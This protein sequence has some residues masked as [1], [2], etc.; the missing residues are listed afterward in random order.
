MKFSRKA[1]IIVPLLNLAQNCTDPSFE[2][3]KR[4]QQF[5]SGFPPGPLTEGGVFNIICQPGFEWTDGNLIVQIT[6]QVGV[7][8]KSF[9]APCVGRCI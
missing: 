5:Q 4:K 2:I 3:N 6:C 1:I 9:P 8:W 7:M